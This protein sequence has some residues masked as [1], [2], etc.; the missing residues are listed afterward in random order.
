MGYRIRKTILLVEDEFLIA[1][2]TQRQLEREGY[3]VIH[4]MSG[5]TALET[6]RNGGE[7]VDLVLMDI[8]LGAGMDGTD[9]A[10][11]MLEVFD[12]PILFL[13]SHTEK[14]IVQ[15]TE[16]VGSYGYV[17]KNSS[18]TVLDAS[19]KMAFKLFE[20]RLS[21]KAKSMEMEA[22]YEEMQVSNEELESAN[23]ELVE[24]QQNL[25]DR[26]AAL[27]NSER[28]LRDIIDFL[29]DATL[30]VDNSGMVIVWNKAME[31]M[32]GIPAAEM[33]GKGNGD[34]T[35]P[36]YGVRRKLL[37]DYLSGGDGE[38]VTDYTNLL[39]QGETLSAEAFCG[40]LYGS[41]GASVFIKASP[42]HDHD[43]ALIGAI[44]SIRD[45]SEKKQ[46]DDALR[47]SERKFRLVFDNAPLGLLHFDVYGKIIICND[48]FVNIVGSARER[49]VGLDMTRL[50]EAR[51]AAAVTSALSGVPGSFEGEYRS[52]TA[53][54]ITPVRVLFTPILDDNGASLGGVGIIEDISE[55]RM[56]EVSIDELLRDKE[57]LLKE[58]HH[59][60]KNNMGVIHG[61]LMMQA[62][63]Q[64]DATVRNVLN[65]AAGRVQ[66]MTVLYD[67]LYRSENYRSLGMREFLTPLVAEIVRVLPS[68][69]PVRT[70]VS[71]GD[72]IVSEKILSSLGIL[73]N[74][75][76][77]NSVKYAFDGGQDA[78]IT[79]TTVKNDDT[80]TLEY[81]DNGVGLPESIS[82]ENS[83]GFGMQLIGMLVAQVKGSIRIERGSGTRFIIE[84][85]A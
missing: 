75:L 54:K 37:M 76:I 77:T 73:V 81:A 27:R 85:D 80:V 59:R 19:I 12:M 61:L 10:A 7:P 29:P 74:E 23:R 46:A 48:R 38:A 41:Q 36:F 72:F 63:A 30:A 78:W 69:Q 43:G 49:L 5:E 1:L 21:L 22:A 71:A 17:V 55:R 82:I 79:V 51:L 52:V 14:E 8:D 2:A 24:Y 68:A 65:D 32:T 20:A 33:L 64:D 28:R 40:S 34:Y 56:A 47:A 15:R 11:L 3:R 84:F 62:G 25:F 4:A 58:T 16:A 9:A 31:D 42:L 57:T 53:D 70:T 60:V 18:F 66:S 44:E 26:E 67:R 39:R 13:S 6:I 50:P 45:I 83:T 35:L